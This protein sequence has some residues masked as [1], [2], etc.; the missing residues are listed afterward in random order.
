MKKENAR[1][2][3]GQF[4]AENY[5]TMSAFARSVN[6]WYGMDIIRI[7]SRGGAKMLSEWARGASKPRKR[8]EI[9]SVVKKYIRAI[10]KLDVDDTWLKVR[11]ITENQNKEDKDEKQLIM[12]FGKT[13][14]E[15]YIKRS[16][17][18]YERM[19]KVTEQATKL[20][21]SLIGLKEWTDKVSECSERINRF[22]DLAKQKITTPNDGA[23]VM[24]GI[25]NHGEEEYAELYAYEMNNWDDLMNLIEDRLFCELSNALASLE[26]NKGAVIEIAKSWN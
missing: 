3:L 11:N 12:T 26:K 22:R 25:R 19:R 15:E 1:T 10:H 8:H 7:K 9:W 23:D 17:E 16:N 6:E 24:V 21:Y 4:V 2:K 20:E 18:R 13:D 5:T 14:L